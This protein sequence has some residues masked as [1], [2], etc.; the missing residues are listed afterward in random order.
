[1]M[2]VIFG[3]IAWKVWWLLEP[4]DDIVVVVEFGQAVTLELLFVAI[5][6]E[7]LSFGDTPYWLVLLCSLLESF[8]C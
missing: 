3:V 5:S 2:W 7:D 6:C 1:M 4:C 8:W